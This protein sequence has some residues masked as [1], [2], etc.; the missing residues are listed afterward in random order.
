[1]IQRA[2]VEDITS[3]HRG[4]VF[5]ESVVNKKQEQVEKSKSLLGKDTVEMLFK[6][7]QDALWILENL[8]VGCKQPEIQEAFRKF[9]A[10]G[11][12]VQYEDRIYV[13]T[14]LVERCLK[15]VPGVNEF[16]VPMNSFFIGGTAPYIYDDRKG[17]GG[18]PPTPEHVVR[19]AQIAQ[20]NR[21]VAGMGR[22]VKLKDEVVQMD[23]M[24]EHCKKP[25]YFAVT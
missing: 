18:I 3:V 1:M 21:P 20:E 22:G 13:T 19:I 25:I 11:L 10:D 23:I 4:P 6:V 15:T 8:G 9:E 2:N 17:K 7:H 16:F 12:A 14:G 24:A 5:E